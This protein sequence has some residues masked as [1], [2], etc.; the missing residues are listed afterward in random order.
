VCAHA[1]E[2]TTRAAGRVNLDITFATHAPRRCN[3]ALNR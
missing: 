1:V 2:L 3:E